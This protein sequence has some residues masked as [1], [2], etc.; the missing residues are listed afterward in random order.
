MITGR[1]RRP[2]GAPEVRVERGHPRFYRHSRLYCRHTTGPEAV[3]DKGA[4]AALFRVAQTTSDTFCLRGR[5]QEIAAAQCVISKPPHVIPLAAPLQ[6]TRRSHRTTRD[7]M[8]IPPV[9]T[10][11]PALSLLFFSFFFFTAGQALLLGTHSS[12][13][14]AV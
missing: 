11:E 10:S 2:R 6:L 12:A 7:E 4:G 1:R 3:Y 9:S 8:L 13:E 14:A 5:Q